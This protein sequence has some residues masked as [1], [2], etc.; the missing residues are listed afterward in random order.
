MGTR[1]GGAAFEEGEYYKEYTVAKQPH[2]DDD[3]RCRLC[4]PCLD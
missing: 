2:D 1:D 3:D 4:I